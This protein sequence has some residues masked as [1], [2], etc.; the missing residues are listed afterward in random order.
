MVASLPD[1]PAG[2]ATADDV[3][4]GPGLPCFLNRD[5]FHSTLTTS[6]AASPQFDFE[7]S[8]NCASRLRTAMIAT[9]ALLPV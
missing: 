9:H 4:R 5:Q 8:P 3:G 7:V 2:R 6:L 1:R